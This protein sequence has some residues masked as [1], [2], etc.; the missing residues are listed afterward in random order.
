MNKF[1]RGFSVFIFILFALTCLCA[2]EETQTNS[3]KLFL[4]T[5][6]E[7]TELNTYYQSILHL[8]DDHRY[9]KENLPIDNLISQIIQILAHKINETR[10]NLWTLNR[11]LIAELFHE[12]LDQFSPH[13]YDVIIL[14]LDTSLE[15]VAA[16]KEEI[17]DLHLKIPSLDE[18]P[19][20]I[21]LQEKTIKQLTRAEKT[22]L[23]VS[24]Q[25]ARYKIITDAEERSITI[26]EEEKS[27]L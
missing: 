5:D 9:H 2:A 24:E 22:L 20:L 23:H 16:D 13:A 7:Y 17:R 11:L 8:L 27:T 14:N 19:L 26:A 18:V 25:M 10:H 21:T 4:L 3:E 15:I 6:A 12:R 1:I